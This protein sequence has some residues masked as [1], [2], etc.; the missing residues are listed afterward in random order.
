MNIDPVNSPS[1]NS[2][3]KLWLWIYTDPLHSLHTELSFS[4]GRSNKEQEYLLKDCF[5]KWEFLNVHNIL[6]LNVKIMSG[7][8]NSENPNDFTRTHYYYLAN[9]HKSAA[10]WCFYCSIKYAMFMAV[11]HKN[12]MGMKGWSKGKSMS[13]ANT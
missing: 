8:T 13:L 1:I 12:G 3:W 11:H 2:K 6:E 5:F 7:K 9:K 10:K 4:S